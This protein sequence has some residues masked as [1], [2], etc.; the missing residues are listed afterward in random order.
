VEKPVALARPVRLAYAK[1]LAKRERP[2]VPEVASILEQIPHIAEDVA[3]LVL[4]AV[5]A[6]VEDAK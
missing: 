4:E 5:P 1:L 2:C 3:E 6:Q